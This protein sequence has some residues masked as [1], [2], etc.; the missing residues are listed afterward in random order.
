MTLST[1]DKRMSRKSRF[2]A[3]GSNDA[4]FAGGCLIAIIVFGL[5]SNVEA[6]GGWTAATL[7]GF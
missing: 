5:A 3:S 2:K 1:K 4:W 7:G 6:A